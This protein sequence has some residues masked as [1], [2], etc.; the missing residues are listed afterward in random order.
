MLLDV[1]CECAVSSVM[2]GWMGNV[3]L[4]HPFSSFFVLV[5]VLVLVDRRLPSPPPPPLVRQCFSTMTKQ[6]PLVSF[7]GIFS[8]FSSL[9][10]WTCL[11]QEK[12]IQ[13]NKQTDRFFSLPSPEFCF[14]PCLCVLCVCGIRSFFSLQTCIHRPTDMHSHTHTP[15]S[16]IE[17][18]NLNSTCSKSDSID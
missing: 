10:L 16:P 15:H 13:S 8:S 12:P 11:G 1:L 7:P 17:K 14:W 3:F 6:A 9:F 2:D 5:L 4:D 18:R